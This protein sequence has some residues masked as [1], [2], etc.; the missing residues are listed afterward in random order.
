VTAEGPEYVPSPSERV[1]DKVAAY[2]RYGSAAGRDI[3]ILALEPV[4]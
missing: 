4:Q 2:A 1:R 3:P